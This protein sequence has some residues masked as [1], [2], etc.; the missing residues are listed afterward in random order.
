MIPGA[1]RTIHAGR[2]PAHPGAVLMKVLPLVLP[3]VRDT[4][5]MLKTIFQPRADP[6]TRLIV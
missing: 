1:V 5:K 6:N 2:K 3:S 4:A